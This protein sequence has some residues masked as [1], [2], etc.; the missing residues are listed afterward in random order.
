MAKLR[1]CTLSE[2]RIFVECGAIESTVLEVDKDELYRCYFQV[3]EASG[4]LIRYTLV[5]Q[6]SDE[7]RS[8]KHPG[9][10]SRI[11]KSENIHQWRV[12][13]VSDQ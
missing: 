12:V 6:R 9:T 7:P 11:L 2:L 8:F 3:Q 10:V 4:G 13:N 1:T 5:T